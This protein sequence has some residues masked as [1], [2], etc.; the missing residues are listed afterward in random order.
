MTKSKMKIVLKINYLLLRK[1]IIHSSRVINEKWVE[2][3]AE[4][5]GVTFFLRAEQYWCNNV[6]LK[7]MTL[8]TLQMYE[9]SVFGAHQSDTTLA[10]S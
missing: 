6:T 3:K 2:V 7:A 4:R 10:T 9:V 1:I 5:D 8:A